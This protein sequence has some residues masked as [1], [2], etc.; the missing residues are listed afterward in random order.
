M[1]CIHN[2]ILVFKKKEILSLMTMWI[3][4]EDI[5]LDKIFQHRKANAA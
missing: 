1:V 3:T 5:K 4:L 2:G